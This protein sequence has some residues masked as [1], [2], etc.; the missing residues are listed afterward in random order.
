MTKALTAFIANRLKLYSFIGRVQMIAL[1]YLSDEKGVQRALLVDLSTGKPKSTDIDE[2]L[3]EQATSRFL[4]SSRD[5]CAAVFLAFHGTLPNEDLS[6]RRRL[7]LINAALAGLAYSP[8]QWASRVRPALLSAKG[9]FCAFA[10]DFRAAHEAFQEAVK[11]LRRDP[12]S[13]LWPAD[14]NG[15]ASEGTRVRETMIATVEV[16]VARALLYRKP[17]NYA[18]AQQQLQ[19]FIDTVAPDT[20]YFAQAHYELARSFFQEKIDKGRPSRQEFEN[21]AERARQLVASAERKTVDM[22]ILRP[23]DGTECSMINDVKGLI[24]MYEVSSKAK[25]K[26]KVTSSAVPFDACWMCEFKGETKLKVCAGCGIA[27]YCSEY[28]Q[29]QHWPSHKQAC[30]AV[31]RK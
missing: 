31:K 18:K 10:G 21:I 20:H 28:C 27:K 1:A 29:R 12:L 5:V 24:A 11:V 23:L 30:K 15:V 16:D 19:H 3:I 8:H 2:L 14:P 6:F 22:P 26:K 13:S 4:N 25:G 17:P 7:Q 9:C